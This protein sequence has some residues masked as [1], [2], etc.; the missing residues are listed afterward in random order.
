MKKLSTTKL[1]NFSISIAFILVASQSEIL[2]C[3][4]TLSYDYRTYGFSWY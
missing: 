4:Y 3:H 2:K 1:H